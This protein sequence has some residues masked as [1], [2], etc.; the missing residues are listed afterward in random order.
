LLLRVQ[1]LKKKI[2]YK[3]R[4]RVVFQW[5]GNNRSININPIFF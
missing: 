2:S 3:K 1:N 4:S 5:S